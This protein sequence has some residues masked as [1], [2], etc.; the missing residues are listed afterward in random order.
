[1]EKLKNPTLEDWFRFWLQDL[2]DRGYI[3]K[4]TE[5][6]EMYPFILFEEHAI[7]GSILQPN[8]KYKAKKKILLEAIQY[9][10]DFLIIWAPKAKGI[11]YIP[12]EDDDVSNHKMLSFR[13]NDLDYTPVEIK[14]PP[15]YGG[16]NTSDASFRV[17]QKWVWEKYQI[18]V[19]K[20]YLYPLKN[21]PTSTNYLWQN[22]FTPSRYFKTDGLT[23]FRPIN[24]WTP[25]QID[26]FL[27]NKKSVR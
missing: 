16:R 7:K 8:G 26:Y 22:T 21:L 4:V 13:H 23:K 3:L 6:K 14:A 17:K 12:Y 20:I 19:Q 11:F 9:T 24:K 15:G 2:L 25:I 10:P 18:L 5:T 27:N 1:M